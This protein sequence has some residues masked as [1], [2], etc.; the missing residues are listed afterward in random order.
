MILTFP[1]SIPLV[2]KRQK[3]KNI[4]LKDCNSL[5]VQKFNARFKMSSKQTES[6]FPPYFSLIG[7]KIKQDFHENFHY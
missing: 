6:H 7:V 1:A 3:T 5:P 2:G 4:C